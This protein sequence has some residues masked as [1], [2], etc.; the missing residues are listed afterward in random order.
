MVAFCTVQTFYIRRQF[1]CCF[2]APTFYSLADP[3]L[4]L[5]VGDS[6]ATA[7]RYFGKVAFLSSPTHAAQD[8][9]GSVST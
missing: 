7:F 8:L 4:S 2:G 1:A 9:P 3:L 5:E 6:A